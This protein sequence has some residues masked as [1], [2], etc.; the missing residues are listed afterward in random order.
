VSRKDAPAHTKPDRALLFLSRL[1]SEFT[2]VHP[3][4]DL[5]DRVMLALHEETGFD[6]CA[7]AL[8]DERHPD[9]LRIQGASGLRARSRGV[10][11]P[12]EKGLH[13]VVMAS[14]MPLLIHDMWED[15]RVQRREGTIRSGIYAPLLVH[16]RAVGVLSAHRAEQRAFTEADL[17]LLTIVARY[18]TGAI[19]IARLHASLYDLAATDALTRLANRRNFL[20]HLASEIARSRRGGH[21]LSIVVLDLDGFGIINDVHGH[22][23]GDALLIH[24]AQTLTRSLRASDLAAR[25]GSDEFG[26]LLPETNGSEAAK[27]ISRLRTLVISI[28][29]QRQASSRVS[30]S[31]G[32]ATWSKDTHTPESLLQH[33]ES[34]LH[35]MKH[36]PTRKAPKRGRGREVA[37]ARR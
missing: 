32:I 29:R 20:S 4:P 2:A 5:I 26:L 13:G 19:E 8:L 22:G 36:R 27:L 25:L 21:A 3:L 12:R 18:L 7:L 6:S 15:P 14:R 28:P 33:A 1:A 24:V 37:A 9:T 16:D 30:L 35:A 10:T 31:Y 11:L 17:S 23:T 34:Q